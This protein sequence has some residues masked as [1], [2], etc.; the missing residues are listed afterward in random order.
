MTLGERAVVTAI[1]CGMVL[2]IAF[3]AI[4]MLY[5][6]LLPWYGRWGDSSRP[7]AKPISVGGDAALPSPPGKPGGLARRCVEPH[8][9]RHA[10][11]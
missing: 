9:V 3:F 1:L 8:E 11:A 5:P 4:G 7:R 10:S 6:E 2:A